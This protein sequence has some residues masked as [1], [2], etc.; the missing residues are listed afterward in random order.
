VHGADAASGSPGRSA[1]SG[2]VTGLTADGLDGTLYMGE[3]AGRGTGAFLEAACQRLRAADASRGRDPAAA[4]A[5]QQPYL[6]WRTPHIELVNPDS[7]C[8]VILRIL[9]S[10]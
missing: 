2:L 1:P 3:T 5:A 7:I 6:V 9:V 4:N 8:F 10:R